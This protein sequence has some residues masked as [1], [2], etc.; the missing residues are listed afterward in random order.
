VGF[1][2]EVAIVAG[3]MA[4]ILGFLKCMFWVRARSRS[5]DRPNGAP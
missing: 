3:T 5:D 2:V 4:G 1:L